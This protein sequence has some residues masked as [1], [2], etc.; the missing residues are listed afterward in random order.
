[1]TYLLDW[2]QR[3]IYQ[4]CLSNGLGALHHLKLD[5]C[6]CVSLLYPPTYPN[7]ECHFAL[8]VISWGLP[9]NLDK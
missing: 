7:N 3:L 2:P 9:W 5:T 1:M 8:G 6:T 4:S